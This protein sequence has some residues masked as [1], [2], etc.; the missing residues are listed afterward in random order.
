MAT[1]PHHC[2][3]QERRGDY[4]VAHKVWPDIQG[5]LTEREELKHG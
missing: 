4:L 2:Q 5:T 3:R 1:Y